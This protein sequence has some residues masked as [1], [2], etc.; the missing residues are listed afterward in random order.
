MLSIED[1]GPGLSS[2]ETVD[3]MWPGRRIDESG[4]G[5]G[6]GLPITREL[7]ELYGGSFHLARRTSAV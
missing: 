3:V 4:P 6:F 7:T 1:D 5:Y 2:E